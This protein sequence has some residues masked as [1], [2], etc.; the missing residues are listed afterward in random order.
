[1]R[2]GDGGITLSGRMPDYFKM[3]AAQTR[4][5]SV[6]TTPEAS[7]RLPVAPR[8]SPASDA[9]PADGI[10]WKVRVA[11]GDIRL[12]LDEG[13]IRLTGA[14]SLQYRGAAAKRGRVHNGRVMNIAILITLKPSVSVIDIGNDIANALNR[15]GDKGEPLAASASSIRI[16]LTGGL[17]VLPV[18][19]VAH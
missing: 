9:H 13:W 16:T 3:R 17:P 15:S 7:A 4:Q 19:A 2:T 6:L 11:A 5:C 18:G 10:V 1:M 14:V 12:Q 8:R